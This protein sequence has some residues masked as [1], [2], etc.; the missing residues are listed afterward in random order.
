MTLSRLL[1]DDAKS[2]TMGGGRMPRRKLQS[3]VPFSYRQ[4]V[5][6]L[7]WGIGQCCSG[8]QIANYGTTLRI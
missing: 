2:A 1:Q 3:W 6:Y 4:S 5:A 7:L 8:L